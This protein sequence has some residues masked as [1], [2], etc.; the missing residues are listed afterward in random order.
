MQETTDL[1]AVARHAIR[2]GC[3]ATTDLAAVAR[4]A[5]RPGCHATRV[6]RRRAGRRAAK[7]S[8]NISLPYLRIFARDGV[9]EEL[10]ARLVRAGYQGL[11][12]STT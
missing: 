9:A 1:A 12:S 11:N 5:I 3:H 6:G 7:A 4:H 10:F 2:P 8:S